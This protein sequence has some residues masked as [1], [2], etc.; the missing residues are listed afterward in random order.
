MTIQEGRAGPPNFSMA[1]VGSMAGVDIP[2]SSHEG[3][4]VFGL[5]PSAD[6]GTVSHG[7]VGMVDDMAMESLPVPGHRGR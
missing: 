4:V 1:L 6:V 5:V 7:F 2:E 3:A